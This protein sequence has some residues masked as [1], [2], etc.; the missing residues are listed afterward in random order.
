MKERTQDRLFAACGIASAVLVHVGLF[1]GVASGQ[2]F[3]KVRRL[4]AAPKRRP[5][6][7]KQLG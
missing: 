4:G 5:V 7:S 6:S 2:A 3:V 1:V